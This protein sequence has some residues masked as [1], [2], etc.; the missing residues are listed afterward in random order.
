MELF[1]SSSGTKLRFRTLKTS[2]KFSV[3]SP[4]LRPH[5]GFAALARHLAEFIEDVGHA[6]LGHAAFAAE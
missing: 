5:A 4:M 6:T 1:L 3:G 2:N